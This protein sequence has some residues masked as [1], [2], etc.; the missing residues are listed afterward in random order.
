MIELHAN[1]ARYVLVLHIKT[2]LSQS[3]IH[4]VEMAGRSVEKKIKFFGRKHW[5]TE[6]SDR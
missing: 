1:E 5:S 4:N 2:S 3:T 6:Q